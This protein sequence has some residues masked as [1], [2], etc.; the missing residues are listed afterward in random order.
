VNDDELREQLALAAVGALSPEERTELDDV[1]RTRPDMQAELDELEAAA[2][3]LGAAVAEPPPPTLRAS[4]LDA[5]ATTPQLPA[6]DELAGTSA[7]AIDEPM[8]AAPTAADGPVAPVVPID[9]HRRRRW[10]AIG[11]VAA[12]VI[13]LLVGVLVVSPWNSDSTDPI[14]AVLQSDDAVEIPMTGELAGFT[15]VHSADQDAAVLT[16]DGIAVPAGDEVYEL[17]AIRG[18]NA[19]EP[20]DTFR[21]SAGG[22]VAVL[23]HGI[24]PASA[25][26]AITAEPA[27][28]SDT[29]TLPI[30]AATA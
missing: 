1:L 11:A 19:P 7:P 21:P 17:W 6:L 25:T 27:G 24:D 29:P 28:G 16:G 2:M 12:A 22:D 8:A 14:A 10:V 20:V 15:I 5:I 3:V 23:L 26:W 30:L 4:I 9:G 18:S 13:A